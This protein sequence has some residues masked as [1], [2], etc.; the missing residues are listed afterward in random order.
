MGAGLL[1]M[2]IRPERRSIGVHTPGTVAGLFAGV[3]RR[4]PWQPKRSH[5]G[6][7]AF[8]AD[9]PELRD[10]FADLASREIEATRQTVLLGQQFDAAAEP[11]QDGREPGLT[12][13]FAEREQ[14]LFELD[15]E[16]NRRFQRL[17]SSAVQSEGQQTLVQL[18]LLHWTTL[19][20]RRGMVGLHTA[21]E[22]LVHDPEC[23]GDLIGDGLLQRYFDALLDHESSQG[24][25]E[26]VQALVLIARQTACLGAQQSA[27]LA[28][29]LY[30]SYR[31]LRS[32]LRTHGLE[33]L[34]P[35]LAQ[36]ASSPLLLFYD[37]EKW[38][39]TD[40]PLARW[41]A[42]QQEALAQGI[43]TERHPA[44]WHGLWLY[45]RRSGHLLGY[46]VT[47]APID[48]NDVDLEALF[49]SIVDPINLG[50]GDCS[51]AEMIQRGTS[52]LGY[53]CAGQ[54]CAEQAS[55]SQPAGTAGTTLITLDTRLGLGRGG[56]LDSPALEIL[57]NA[58][59]PR[60]GGGGGCGQ[61]DLGGGWS[62]EA[63]MV[64]CVSQRALQPGEAQMR[65][66]AEA[67]G[68]CA[69]PL[70]SA[71]KMITDALMG[72]VKVGTFCQLA[73]TDNSGESVTVTVPVNLEGEN[74]ETVVTVSSDDPNA[75]AREAERQGRL[76]Q[77]LA[78]GYLKGLE[79]AEADGDTELADWIRGRFEIQMDRMRFWDS[80][81]AEIRR[82]YG[83]GDG[84]GPRGGSSGIASI[85]RCPADTP[86][87]GAN[88]CTGMSEWARNTM[89]C[90]QSSIVSQPAPPG[91]F[92]PLE[93]ATTGTLPD[94]FSLLLEDAAPS[95]LQCWYFD[96][97][98][99]ALT[100]AG[101][102]GCGCGPPEV[103]GE[104]EGGLVGSCGTLDCAD[105]TP[106]FEGGRCTCW[107]GGGVVSPTLAPFELKQVQRVSVVHD[108][109][110]SDLRLP[111]S[112]EGLRIALERVARG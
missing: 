46:R 13:G 92:D 50:R 93:S 100:A 26:A 56:V 35:A 29:D 19:L 40:G 49:A 71:T 37:V 33:R 72:G 10:A 96:C 103:F 63:D 99:T 110:L 90:F 5:Q 4:W 23:A 3:L 2:G 64:R 15:R 43:V 82:K 11:P 59:S 32:F 7:F 87:C 30:W 6:R 20:R 94:C 106:R 66:V 81:A 55:Q 105:G 77:E 18:A 104:R 69:N 12:A 27:L 62:R 73:D 95:S 97:G 91:V 89:A 85:G 111:I 44:F 58:A 52:I 42:E 14:E 60:E 51:F 70:D 38:R 84:R 74:V 57:C 41:F 80:V 1:A 83:T 102:G 65:C 8:V 108:K 16:I 48:E 9:A 25:Q 78:T 98:P 31:E 112:R 61:A 88:D 28:S 107:R 24:Q 75:V 45:D 109:R 54:A 22:G 36:A 39:G 34:I 17:Y 76:A 47:A 79:E 67:T 68:R 21:V 101:A 86:D 53:V